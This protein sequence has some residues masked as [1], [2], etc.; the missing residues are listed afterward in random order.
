[1]K[2]LFLIDKSNSNF[3][4]LIDYFEKK[5]PKYD[6]QYVVIDRRKEKDF[7]G[8]PNTTRVTRYS[9]FIFNRSLR[10]KFERADKIIVSGIFVWQYVLSSFSKKIIQKCYLQFWGGDYAKFRERNIRNIIDKSIIQKILNDA[11]GVILLEISEKK[12]FES[13]FRFNGKYFAVPVTSIPE[14]ET[15]LLSSNFSNSTRDK[16]RII[17]GNSATETNCHM[18]IF[19]M[20]KGKDW[21]N[22]EI[23]CPLSYGD[24]E[25][26]KFIINEGKKVFGENFIPITEMM[27]YED[28]IQFLASCDVGIYNHNRQQ[29]LGNISLLNRLG[30]KVYVRKDGECWNHYSKFGIILNSTEDIKNASTYEILKWDHSNAELNQLGMMQRDY[31]FEA[32]WQR[33]LED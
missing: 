1:M 6:K 32:E 27:N 18:E 8:L 22:V 15:A 13:I 21:T 25:Y 31:S 26:A 10:N 17:I 5:F 29:G 7:S 4:S 14:K 11:K 9:E 24:M 3:R 30:K 19:E 20:L 2:I 28:Y 33:I 12:L 23:C 16:K